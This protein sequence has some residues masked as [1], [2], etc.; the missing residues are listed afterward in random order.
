MVL[1]AGCGGDTKTWRVQLLSSSTINQD[2]GGESLPVLVR[3]YQLKGK[4]RFQQATF[5]TLWKNDKDALEGDLVDRK[6]MT[7]QPDAKTDLYLEVDVRHG[8]AYLG[9][10]ALFRQ[11]GVE[12]WRQIVEASS[13]ALN[14]MTPKVKLTLHHNKL[15]LAD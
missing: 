9:V 13:S 15:M 10:M 7:V 5:K 1:G 3:V 14:P 6:E 8:V 4:E 2:D 11:P 12:G